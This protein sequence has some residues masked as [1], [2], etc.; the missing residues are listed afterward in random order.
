MSHAGAACAAIAAG[1]AAALARVLADARFDVRAALA[2]ETGQPLLHH[3]VECNAP[4]CVRALLDAGASARACTNR[5]GE[6]ALVPAINRRRH[7]IAH[8][9]LAGGADLRAC[10]AFGYS[11]LTNAIGARDLSTLSLFLQHDLELH[12]LLDAKFSFASVDAVRV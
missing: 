8:M 9:L 2:L 10:D 12:E 1:D 7:A 11:L 6:S 5:T 3:A 4:S